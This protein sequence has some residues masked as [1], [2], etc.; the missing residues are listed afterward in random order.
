M[1]L[2]ASE[3]PT[4]M[5][6]YSFLAVRGFFGCK[7][8]NKCH[9]RTNSHN[10]I[11]KLDLLIIHF[12]LFDYGLL[13]VTGWIEQSQSGTNYDVDGYGQQNCK[14]LFAQG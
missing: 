12:P 11:T 13:G 5:V 8:T 1:I 9:K 10:E 2:I 6:L 3:K 7:N 14:S 4:L